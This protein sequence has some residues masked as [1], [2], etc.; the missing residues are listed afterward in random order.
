MIELYE[1]QKKAVEELRSGSILVGGTGSGKTLT[2]IAYYY[3]VECGGKISNGKCYPM[4]RPKDLY[5]ITTAANRDKKK[6]EMELAP[7]HLLCDPSIKVVVDSWNNIT[8]YK[9]VK[10]AFFIFDEQRVGGKGTWAKTFVHIAKQ[11]RWILLSATPGDTWMDYVSVFIANGF[12]RN[13]TQFIN[14]HVVYSPYVKYRIDH[15]ENCEKLYKYKEKV[16]VRMMFNRMTRAHKKYINCEYDKEAFKKVEKT[17][18]NPYKTSPIQNVSE[19]GYVLR[20]IVNEDKSRF[21]KVIELMDTL[22]TAVIFYNF[23][24]EWET[25]CDLQ[26]YGYDVKCWNGHYHDPI[27]NGDKWVY[28]VNYNAGA[29]G[30]DCTET[31]NMIFYSMNYSYKMMTQSEGRIDRLNTSYP[32]LYYYYLTSSSPIDKA[33][34]T[35]LRN[36]R[37][38][39]LRKFANFDEQK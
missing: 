28:L 38:F 6:Y 20:R 37:D 4:K 36:K 12:Y 30:W 21:E 3:T 8:K 7:F 27:P 17:R 25:L 16:I 15:Y 9:D 31:N 5:I 24:F 32:D 29:E 34:R 33:I 11:N 18:W 2:A 39:N 19:Y 26:Y 14:E 22:S 13:R 1:H 23:D 10:Q 35:A